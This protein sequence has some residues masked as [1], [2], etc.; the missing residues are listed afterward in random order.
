MNKSKSFQEKA[1][2]IYSYREIKSNAMKEE[3][4]IVQERHAIKIIVIE[5]IIKETNAFQ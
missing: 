2:K 1:S 4:I 5:N 3:G